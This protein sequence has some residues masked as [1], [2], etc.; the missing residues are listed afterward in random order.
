[1][2]TCKPPNFLIDDSIS[3]DSLV[4]KTTLKSNFEN[5]VEFRINDKYWT[6]LFLNINAVDFILH[7]IWLNLNLEFDT[8]FQS[9]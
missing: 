5:F 2:Y 4:H 9:Y 8:Q 1:M 6:Y 7:Q 3:C